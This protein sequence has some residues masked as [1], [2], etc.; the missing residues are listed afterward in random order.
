MSEADELTMQ[1]IPDK[2]PEREPVLM[3]LDEF[4]PDAL[5]L[6]PEVD[7]GLVE[8]MNE[9]G[10]QQP[11]VAGP[12]QNGEREV[13]AGNRRIKA[14]RRLGWTEI[15][16]FELTQDP[17]NTIDPHVLAEQ[18]NSTAKPNPIVQLEAIEILRAKGHDEKGIAR[19]LKLKLG[20]VRARLRLQKLHHKIRDGVKRNKISFGNADKIAKMSEET[21]ERLAKRFQEDG[22]LPWSVI[23]EE[24]RKK[25]AEVTEGFELDI[26]ALPGADVF[27]GD[28][29]P[30]EAE[31]L[32]NAGGSDSK[33]TAGEPV[34]DDK[35]EARLEAKVWDVLE[36]GK[37]PS[38]SKADA[39]SIAKLLGLG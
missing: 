6:S 39:E 4:A 36:E 16:G 18:L 1:L 37:K 12:V 33:A 11:I 14:A 17:N 31:T 25:V 9:W 28:T 23:D 34:L 3:K 38:W 22:K 10:L 30:T 35:E 13:Y 24:R 2:P 5:L 21:Q 32:A 19:A 8:S 20:T 7:Q 27:G 26:G 29:N 15:E